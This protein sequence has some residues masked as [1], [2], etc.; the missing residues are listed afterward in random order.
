MRN[1]RIYTPQ[2]LSSGSS[3]QL[4]EQASIHLSKVLRFQMG[5]KIRLFNGLGGQY[6]ASINNIT[7]K[8]IELFIGDFFP[9]NF[10]SPLSSH[11][12]LGVSKGDKMDLI[13]Q[14]CT[15]LGV[16]AIYPITTERCDV[17]MDAE[18]WQKKVDRWQDIAISACEQ[19]GRN[20]IPTI[21]AVQPFLTWLPISSNMPCLLLHPEA[22]I[23]LN[24]HIIQSDIAMAFGPEGGFSD[25]ELLQAKKLG[26]ITAQL[27]PR[28]LRAETAPIAA[29]AIAQAQWGD[30]N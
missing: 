9:D 7:K 25:Q 15:E 19:S 22:E 4:E 28:V 13:V 21:H 18:R 30:F 5:D 20:T 23:S 16:T 11:I 27:G 24:K 10:Q 17:K 26:A 1:P 2:V 6:S 8:H 3:I 12:A 14:K 29:L